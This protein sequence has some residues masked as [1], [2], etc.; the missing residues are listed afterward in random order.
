MGCFKS[1]NIILNDIND[2]MNEFFFRLID[3]EFI[4]EKIE[5]FNNTNKT[6]HEFWNLTR[7]L[8]IHPN[9]KFQVEFW[10][11]AFV[12]FY[13]VSLD[14]ILFLFILLCD[15]HHTEKKY[16]I[17]RYL[18]SRF[19]NT[20]S[21]D[22]DLIM[23]LSEF[24]NIILVYLSC[25]T[26]IPFNIL[27]KTKKNSDNNN[28]DFIYSE[29]NI[30]SFTDDF[31][32]NFV[33]KNYYINTGEF[34]NENFDILIDDNKMRKFIFDKYMKDNSEDLKMTCDKVQDSSSYSYSMLYKDNL[35]GDK[36]K[37]IHK[38]D[39]PL[40]KSTDEKLESDI[41][42]LN[43][44]ETDPDNNSEEIKNNFNSNLSE[45]KP[46]NTNINAGSKKEFRGSHLKYINTQ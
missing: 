32:K 5:E 15:A 36:D 9:L 44:N 42:S 46:F 29:S 23:N 30:K 22:D 18:S 26:N 14:G 13:D 33:R 6:Y 39:K 41:R 2:Q 20:I 12:Q 43:R 31:I 11:S 17:K 35:N 28:F 3:H 25:L 19:S 45:Y 37:L 16:L 10:E 7:L 38:Q 21:K 27:A 1:K 4:I 40:S 24:K 34:F 8:G